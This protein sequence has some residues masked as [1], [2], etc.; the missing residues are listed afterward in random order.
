MM[1][2]TPLAVAAVIAISYL[3][4]YLLSFLAW[5]VMVEDDHHF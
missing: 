4:H 3:L 2:T 1:L 5:P